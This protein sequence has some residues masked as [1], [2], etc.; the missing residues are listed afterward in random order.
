MGKWI[1]RILVLALLAVFLF[2]VGSIV[3]ILYQYKASDQLYDNIAS[4]YTTQVSAEKQKETPGGQ[5]A[6]EGA[7][8]VAEVPPISV[9]FQGLQAENQDVTG[10]IYCEDTAIN[11][12]VVQ[13]EDNDFYLKHNYDRTKRAAGS[14]FVEAENSA[15]FADS[16]TI[17]YGH[18]MKNGSMFACL[19][20]WADQAFYESHPVMWL[21]TPTQDYKIILFSGYTTSATSDTYTIFRGAGEELDAYLEKCRKQSNFEADIELDREAHYVL[22]ST[23]AYVFDNARTV[24]HGMM[25]PVDS[26]GGVPFQK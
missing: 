18:H 6:A 17:L 21:L 11:Y 1:R 23:C 22:L 20:K 24:L 5:D 8:K 2:S 9:D 26:A 14:I 12:P 4:Q 15:N 10:W 3:M 19:D 7:P 25:V 16:N 13:G